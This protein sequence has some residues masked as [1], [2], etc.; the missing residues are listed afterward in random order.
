[1]G[2]GSL[3]EGCRVCRECEEEL[4]ASEVGSGEERASDDGSKGDPVERP[5]HYKSWKM[6]PFLFFALNNLPFCEATVIKYVMRWRLKSGIEDLR[7]AKRVIEMM[8]D[9]EE[10]RSNM[11]ATA[12]WMGKEVGYK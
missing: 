6:E 5:D 3:W 11:E 10:K 4:A 1:M 8:I 7:K 9:F 2:Y 12:E